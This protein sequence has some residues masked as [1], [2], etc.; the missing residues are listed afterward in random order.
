MV[1]IIHK[2]EQAVIEHHLL[3]KG[4]RVLV[5]LSGGPDSMALLYLLNALKD[6]FEIEIAAAHLD[7]AIR[8]V[9]AREREFCRQT[10]QTLKIQFYSKRVNI[11]SLARRRGLSLEE[12]G[13]E[14]RYAYFES[15]AEKYGY[16]KIATG[17]TFDDT[18]ETVLLNI[19][20][21]CGLDGLVGIPR[22]R[23]RIIRPL[24]DLEKKE[25][26]KWLVARKIKYVRDRSN[27]S[28]IYARNRIRLRM[29]PEL[30]KINPAARRNIARLSEI[31]SE[32]LEYLSSRTVSAYMDA[33]VESGKGKIALDLGKLVGY[34]KSL[35]KKVLN[36]AF[37]NLSGDTGN[38]SSRVISRALSIAEGESGKK[39]P[40][41]RGFM[42][43]KSQ[44]RIAILKELSRPGRAKLR[45]PGRTEIP[46]HRGYIEA[47]IIEKNEIENYDRNNLNVFLD[48]GE[49]KNIAVRFWRKGDKI[50]P[51]GMNG[52]R[53]LSDI[54]IDSKI[55]EYERGRIPL[56]FSG[57][58][59][60]WIV[61]IM[62]S[63]DF[64]VADNTKKV[65][66]LRYANLDN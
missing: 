10:C 55:P 40:L 65:L 1:D 16:T 15:L 23:G 36:E 47:R 18:I 42:I 49:M 28:L 59:L 6:R 30:E 20:R 29:L 33:L 25:L 5:A 60:A 2:A 19:A 51:L 52:H 66:N 63:D 3:K 17:H 41:G 45:I 37:K 64:K 9:S 50:K 8:K 38:L 4:D 26:L 43:E 13:R 31:V 7:H 11:P 27:R 22:I 24:L 32:E 58:E 54:F 61:G 53:R 62:I 57:G 46:L 35:K 34:D 21:G 48:L 56:V 14:T 39:A 44:G 12:A